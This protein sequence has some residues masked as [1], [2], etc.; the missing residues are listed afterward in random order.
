M[1][2]EKYT[3]IKLTKKNMGSFEEYIPKAVAVKILSE[4]VFGWGVVEDDMASGLVLGETDRDNNSLILLWLYVDEEIRRQGVGRM[5]FDKACSS[6]DGSPEI[7]CR[8]LFPLHQDLEGFLEHLGFDIGI[9]DEDRDDQGEAEDSVHIAVKGDYPFAGE[10]TAEWLR[11]NVHDV[12]HTMPRLL[13]LMSYLEKTGYEGSLMAAAGDEP[14]I[15]IGWKDDHPGVEIRIVGDET[16]EERYT[17]ML[18]METEI[19]EE[20]AEYV[21]GELHLWQKQFKIT[22]GRFDR[23]HGRLLFTA[24]M[25]VDSGIPEPPVIGDFIEEF[26]EETGLFFDAVTEQ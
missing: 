10:Q 1:K 13:S 14:G 12:G 7:H 9:A 20:D 17:I 2:S 15:Y 24:A 18:R 21:E 5:L 22:A 6:M 23:E 19:D 8:Y 11:E 16:D 25:P 3:L 4:N 26:L